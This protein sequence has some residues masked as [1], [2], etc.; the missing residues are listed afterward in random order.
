MSM[1]SRIVLAVASGPGI[2][3]PQFDLR[4]LRCDQL[5]D[6]DARRVDQMVVDCNFFELSNATPIVEISDG[7]HKSHISVHMTDGRSHSVSYIGSA[8]PVSLSKLTHFVETRG[9]LISV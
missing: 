5:S 2:A 8:V 4:E 9:R 3:S 7:P 6:T 1:F